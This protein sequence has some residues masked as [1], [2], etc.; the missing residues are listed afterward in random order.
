MN[1]DDVVDIIRDAGY[2]FLATIDGQQPRVRPLMPYFD[3]EFNHFLIALGPNSRAKEQIKKNANVEICFVDRTMN[4]CR[5]T[6]AADTSDDMDKKQC[7]WDNSPM[8]KQ[9]FSGPEDE[10]LTLMVVKPSQVE[11]MNPHL[12]APE[13]ISLD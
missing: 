8:M 11:G 12:E 2:G 9:Y 5:V 13:V 4:F 1:K 10:N 3:E 7:L 6:G